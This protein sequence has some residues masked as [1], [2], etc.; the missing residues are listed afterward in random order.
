MNRKSKKYGNYHKNTGNLLKDHWAVVSK[1]IGYFIFYSISK[2][3]KKLLCNKNIIHFTKK[4]LLSVFYLQLIREETINAYGYITFY[5]IIF[6]F[7]ATWLILALLLVYNR[8]VQ[9]TAC[10]SECSIQHLFMAHF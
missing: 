1:K 2:F 8:G 4:K 7:S 5:A 3:N 10:R 6:W 9:H